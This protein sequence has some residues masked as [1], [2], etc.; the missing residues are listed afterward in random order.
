MKKNVKVTILLLMII[1]MLFSSY[2]IKANKK[3]NTI[4]NGKYIY[5]ILRSEDEAK[6]EDTIF[7][8]SSK[9]KAL[10]PLITLKGITKLSLYKNNLYF[11][12]S[13]E[14][15]IYRMNL[16]GSNPQIIAYNTQDFYIYKDRIYY[17]NY[18]DGSLLSS[19]ISVAEISSILK[20]VGGLYEK[21]Y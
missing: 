16:D 1:F 4:N 2:K 6:K 20:F 3:I 9:E 17:E 11:I 7:A 14:H 8:K 15:Q 10:V 18:K 12:D 5:F 21:K 13:S 19:D